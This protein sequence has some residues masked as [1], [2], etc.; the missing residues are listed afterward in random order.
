MNRL[1]QI[2][3]FLREKSGAI[4]MPLKFFVGLMVVV[5]IL[6]L[7]SFVAYGVKSQGQGALET[8]FNIDKWL[9]N[10]AN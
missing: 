3:A 6:L 9:G 1:E 2:K 7:V 10:A 8:L 5:I 4:G